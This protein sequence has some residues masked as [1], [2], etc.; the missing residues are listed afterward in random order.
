VSIE[1]FDLPH[2][3]EPECCLHL[4]IVVSPI[5]DNLAVVIASSNDAPVEL[6]RNHGVD[7][8]VYEASEISKGEGGPT[9][10]TRPLLRR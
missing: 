6:L 4:L 9:C 5:R 3:M 8:H 10:L 7:V 1:A 2:D